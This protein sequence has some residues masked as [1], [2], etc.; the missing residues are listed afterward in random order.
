MRFSKPVLF[1]IGVAACALVAF[2]AVKAV[3]MFSAPVP[4]SSGIAIATGAVKLG[5]PF[6]L[7]DQSGKPVTDKDFRGRYMLIYFGY[8]YCPDVCPTE[9][10]A[11]GRAL[12]QLGPKA[13]RIVPIFITVDPARDTAKEMGQFVKAFY[14]RMVGLTGTPAE[15]AKVA[16]KFRVYYSLGKPSK[17]GAM[18]YLV[19]HTSFLYL[20]GPDGKFV[21]IYRGGAG[22]D[23][24]ARE[25]RAAIG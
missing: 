20:M 9:L 12:D 25:L 13:E 15:I 23:A 8:T 3:R 17:P 16:K 7:T 5:G 19:N 1:A 4:A 21:A 14:P 6:A 2:V 10:Q 22:P 24:I 11:I 18:D